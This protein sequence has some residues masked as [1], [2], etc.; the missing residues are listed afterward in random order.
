M[1]LLDENKSLLSEVD[2][3]RALKGCDNI[4]I[5]LGAT[6]ITKGVGGVG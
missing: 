3:K 5:T 1:I 4:L 6:R 2:C